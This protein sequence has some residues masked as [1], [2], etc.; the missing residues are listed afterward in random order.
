[1]ATNLTE[2]RKFVA[3]DVMPCPEPIID[4]ELLAAAQKYCELTHALR[5]NHTADISGLTAT[6][7]YL[8][9]VDIDLSTPCAGLRIVT[10]LKFN[11]DGY[12][13]IPEELLLF[14]TSDIPDDVW[15]SMKEDGKMYFQITADT[16]LRVYERTPASETYLYM[17]LACKPNNS[18]TSVNDKLYYDHRDGICALARYR[19]LNM[20]NKEWSDREGAGVA[21]VEYRREVSKAKLRR[22]KN[23]TGEPGTVNPRQFCI[24]C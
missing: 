10:V 2:F 23:N 18:Q 20:A 12:P 3:P 9:S 14:S 5:V 6:D 1:M 13:W 15:E 4:R 22:F 19:I 24:E 11:L 16:T 7:A 8:D 21:F 17:E